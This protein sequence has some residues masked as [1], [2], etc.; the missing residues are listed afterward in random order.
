MRTPVEALAYLAERMSQHPCYNAQIAS[1]IMR[2]DFTSAE[3]TGGDEADISEWCAVCLLALKA[4][5]K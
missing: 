1:D 4:A 5:G 3:K 2:E